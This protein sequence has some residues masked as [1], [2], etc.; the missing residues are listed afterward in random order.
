[1]K[2][3]LFIIAILA[4]SACNKK[5]KTTTE[6]VE[7]TETTSSTDTI[8]LTQE[9]LQLMKV[10]LGKPERRQMQ[11]IITANGKVTV[12]ANDM[13]DIT[14][15]FKGRVEKI[16]VHE[17]QFVKKGDVLMEL[18]SP[19]M[20]NL[21]ED[22]LKAK[23]E[24]HFLTQELDRQ[25]IMAK[26]NVGANKNLQ[27][28]ESKVFYQNTMLKSAEAKLKLAH[29]PPPQYDSDFET[30]ILIKTPI[31]GYLDHFPVS[32]GTTVNEGM[33]LA[34][35]ESFD[36]LHL[37][38]ALFEKDLQQVKPNQKVR[39][40]FADPSLPET[41]GHIEYVG[42]DIDPITKTATLHVPF[43]P[44]SGKIIATD[45]SVVAS[46]ETDNNSALAL[47]ESAV[48]QDED[49]FYCFTLENTK[50]KTLIFKKVEILLRGK[51]NG[52]LG[53]SDEL[54]GKTVVLRGANVLLGESKKSA[55]AE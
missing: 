22:Y 35:V 6:T 55:M 29:L 34:H 36:D 7:K 33:K 49:K 39:V 28:I 27:E 8:R 13:A 37:D 30:K 17:G 2:N 43:T 20:I 41:T 32:I 53:V 46:I 16:N 50:D 54:N 31:S 47:P 9:Q 10:E 11:G 52:W 38:I 25:R 5:E 24:L 14:A 19:D 12:L 18:I 40:R 15:L 45:M 26:E 1:M 23:S 44:P 51:N 3:I 48:V 4:F 42:R 21:Q